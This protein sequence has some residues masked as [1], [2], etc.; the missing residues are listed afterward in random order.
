MHQ[1]TEATVPMKRQSRLQRPTKLGHKS[2][3]ALHADGPGSSHNDDGLTEE[4]TVTSK[5]S[6]NQVN[7]ALENNDVKA[8]MAQETGSPPLSKK[9]MKAKA[10]G[11]V[12]KKTKKAEKEATKAVVEAYKV[13]HRLPEF[14]SEFNPITKPGTQLIQTMVTVAGR[15]Q[16]IRGQ[17]KPT[18]F[19]DI[20]GDGAK[21]Q[22]VTSAKTY[23]AGAKAFNK[24]NKTIKIGDMIGARGYAGKTKGGT[25]SVFVVELVVL[26]P[27]CTTDNNIHEEQKTNVGCESGKRNEQRKKRD[28]CIEDES[29]KNDASSTGPSV[30][31]TSAAKSLSID[32]ALQ[33]ERTAAVA[34]AEVKLDEPLSTNTVKK[35]KADKAVSKRKK[36]ETEATKSAVDAY[37]THR[38]KDFISEFDPITK[39][40]THLIQNKVAVAGRVQSIRGK[41]E[42]RLFYK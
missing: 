20:H 2:K 29:N 23:A 15:V 30:T 8:A 1:H 37:V 39:P 33:N 13:S 42:E 5:N 21:L 38:L 34:E 3:G 22:L 19:Y 14:I 4:A 9:K 7:K 27:L 17:G 40:G 18:M 12:Q 35:S 26:G 24:I 16:A 28:F 31:S 25:L 11:A 6:N 10:V 32:E 41:G 36:A